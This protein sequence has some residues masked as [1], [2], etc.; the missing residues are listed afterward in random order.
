LFTQVIRQADPLGLSK[1]NLKGESETWTFEK[2]SK[3]L[4][5]LIG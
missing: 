3:I 1:E 4:D 5:R 2:N